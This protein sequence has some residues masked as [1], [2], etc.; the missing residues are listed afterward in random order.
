MMI[1]FFF[2]LMIC[3][4]DDLNGQL[5]LCGNEYKPAVEICKDNT[6]TAQKLVYITT[7]GVPK[8]QQTLCE[9][10]ITSNTS[11]VDISFSFVDGVVPQS[12]S[13]KVNNN[14]IMSGEQ[15]TFTTEDRSLTLSVL[16]NDNYTHESACLMV[17]LSMNIKSDTT[18]N[19]VCNRTPVKPSTSIATSLPYPN[20]SVVTDKYVRK[21]ADKEENNIIVPVV[22]A[23]I[24]VFVCVAVVILIV[25]I[26]RRRST[27]RN[28][29]PKIPNQGV[30]KKNND[31]EEDDYYMTE[32]P[33]YQTADTKTNI[34]NS[35]NEYH[36][37]E[38][39]KH[40]K[41]IN[42]GDL[43][44]NPDLKQ[45]INKENHHDHSTC[46]SSGRKRNP[47]VKAK[48]A[49]AT[50]NNDNSAVNDNM[51]DTT[52]A[53]SV[54]P[55]KGFNEYHH[56]SNAGPMKL[57]V[58]DVYNTIGNASKFPGHEVEEDVSHYHV[59]NAR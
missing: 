25:I 26:C 37:A 42:S 31:D 34:D 1:L 27:K 55:F 2:L 18:F 21:T 3:C 59:A 45:F 29:Q 13:F 35:D 28:K 54:Q 40:K 16:T 20:S 17:S 7:K 47:T 48:T 43:K 39:A 46:V 52:N 8:F 38:S 30:T 57:A 51:Y 56:L 24:A 15:H 49:D 4:I 41:Q 53:A 58:V 23:S 50:Q 11:D 33:M 5:R 9:C 44:C 32:N 22:A 14:E 6:L 36:Y 12:L 19:V 10:S